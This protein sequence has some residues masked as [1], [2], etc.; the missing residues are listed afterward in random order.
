MNL[1]LGPIEVCKRRLAQVTCK[2]RSLAEKFEAQEQ[3]DRSCMPASVR[4]ILRNKRLN[5]LQCMADDI[6]WPD[7]SLFDE[8]RS[9]F[10]LVGLAADS[11]VFK[12]AV[13]APQFTE[14]ELAKRSKFIRPFILGKMNSRSTS[15]NNEELLE[16][17]AAEAG[18]KNWLQGPMSTGCVQKRFGDSWVPVRR[19][20]VQQKGKIRPI[21]DF[22]ENQ[23]NEAWG[24]CEAITLQA[25][26]YVVWTVAAFVKHCVFERTVH[27]RL[28]DGRE[29]RAPV[30]DGWA[31]DDSAVLLT[32]VDLKSAYKQLPVFPGP[33]KNAVVSWRDDGACQLVYYVMNTLPFGAAAAV[34]HFNCVSRLLWAVGTKSLLVPW[35]NYFDDFPGVS[36]SQTSVP[37]WVP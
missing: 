36:M 16:L 23:V 29:L 4:S 6:G 31:K 27:L 37:L 30:H 11:G 25:K 10:K 9:G 19:F 26:E 13:K 5:L 12:R 14:E 17:T 32:T 20:A 28:R 3:K 8:L 22:S 24:C 33:Q 7:K 15:E 21:D 2:W 35:A 1:T 18:E 34:H